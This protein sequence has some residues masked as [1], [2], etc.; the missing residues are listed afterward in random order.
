MRKSVFLDSIWSGNNKPK[1]KNKNATLKY[2]IFKTYALANCFLPLLRRTFTNFTK[3][4]SI[5]LH[6]EWLFPLQIDGPI[7]QKPFP[8]KTMIRIY[9]LKQK[10]VT[11]RWILRKV[12]KVTFG[13]HFGVEIISPNAG[14]NTKHKFSIFAKP[15]L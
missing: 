11:F 12:Q 14:S 1:R 7:Q 6:L 2:G 3:N 8:S 13:T 9:D 5:L 15:M 4:G 10:K